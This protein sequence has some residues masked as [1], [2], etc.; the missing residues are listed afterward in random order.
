[1]NMKRR[2]VDMRL[3]IYND[4]QIAFLGLF[5]FYETFSRRGNLVI[6]SVIA[7]SNVANKNNI[8]VYLAS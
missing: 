2:N 5:K 7:F 3:K 6:F 1:M 4:S 8:Y